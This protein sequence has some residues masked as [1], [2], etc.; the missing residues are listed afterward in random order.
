MKSL[1]LSL[2]LLSLVLT[3]QIQ[4]AEIPSEKQK[5]IAKMLRL[6]GMEKLM[7]QM[8]VQMLSSLRTQI[9]EV[10]EVFWTKFEKK[11]DMKALLDEIIPLYDKYYTLEDLRA[12]NTFYESAAGKKVLST[13]PQIMAESMKIGEAWGRRIGEQAAAEAQAELDKQKKIK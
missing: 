4:S 13:L 10:P 12:V 11:M 6:T 9:V 1:I 3:P 2:L 8:K 7:D 5:E